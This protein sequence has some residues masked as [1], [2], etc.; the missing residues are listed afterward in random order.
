VLYLQTYTFTLIHACT[1]TG[2][3]PDALSGPHSVQYCSQQP[4]H[5]YAS[6]TKRYVSIA[7]VASALPMYDHKGR[8]GMRMHTMQL[9]LGRSC[10]HLESMDSSARVLQHALG[11]SCY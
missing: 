11:S 7:A 8:I 5:R 2:V 4:Q 3:L 1:F 6:E 9:N 10:C